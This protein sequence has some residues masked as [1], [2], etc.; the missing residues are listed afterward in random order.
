MYAML[1]FWGGGEVAGNFGYVLYI[2]TISVCFA[3]QLSTTSPYVATVSADATAAAAADAAGARGGDGG[4]NGANSRWIISDSAV[5]EMPSRP[6]ADVGVGFIVVNMTS[7]ATAWSKMRRMIITLSAWWLF[8]M[9]TV[10]QKKQDTK[11][12]PITSPNVNR[13]SQFFHC[14]TQW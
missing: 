8:W 2:H 12:L 11:L 3:V 14:Q 1:Y 6:S 9:Y 7:R 10:S 4:A 5:D 13:F